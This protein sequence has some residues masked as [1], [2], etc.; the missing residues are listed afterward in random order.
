M[1]TGL[2]SLLMVIALLSPAK[3][4]PP[5]PESQV[6][7]ASFSLQLQ[8]ELKRQ[9]PFLKGTHITRSELDQLVRYLVAHE[10][11]ETVQVKAET[12]EGKTTYYLN[13]GRTRR[14]SK[15]KV[16]GLDHLSENEVRNVLAVDEKSVF[17]QQ[18][19]IEGGERVR[20]LYRDRGF[21]NTVIDL[22]FAR[23]S[24]TEVAVE[25][26]IK[27]GPQTLIEAVTLVAANPEFENAFEKKIRRSLL[28]EPLTDT[29]LNSLRKQMRQLFSEKRFLKAD[30]G[31]PEVKFNS[32]ESKASLTFTITNSEQYLVDLNG[33]LQKGRGSVM[34]SMDL[35]NFFSTNP[36][37]G[38]E[39]ATRVKNFYLKEGFARVEVRGEELATNKAFQKV[40]F[41]DV[42][43]GPPVKIK[44]IRF[45]GRY[46]FPENYYVKF[47]LNHSSEL[48]QD[49]LYNRED[50]EAGLK[51]LIIDRQN[52]GYLRAKVVSVKTA[53][54]GTHKEEVIITVNLEEGPLTI[55]ESLTFEGNSSFSESQLARLVGLKVNEALKLNVLEDGIAK[56]KEFY[57]NSGYLEMNLS[58]ERE[59][60]VNYNA[61]STQASVKFKIYE[62]PKIVVGSV[63]IEGNS[64]T[65]DYVILKELEFKDGDTLTPQ[66]IEE[67]TR[68][69]QRLGHFNTV[70][71]KTLEEK[72]QISNRTVIVRVAD[73]D[74]GLI[75]LG[76]GVN[77]ELGLTVRGYAGLAYRNILGTGRGI[78]GRVEGSYNTTNI[79]YLEHKANV[80]YL[81]PYL[82][83][84]RTNGR[85][86][87][88]LSEYVSDYEVRKGTQSKQITWSL[89][90][91]VTS[92]LFVSYDL[93]SSN[94]LRDF[95]L[96]NDN[97]NS[98]ERTET[99][100]VTTGPNI[101][102][103]YRDHP[104]NPTAG[105]FT[106]LNAEYG[107]P[108]L[109]SSD[110]IHYA[111]AFASFTHYKSVF[112]PGW[113][114]A[115]S[116]RGGVMR[117]F[118]P[119]GGVPYD[120]KGFTLGGQSSIRGF[121]PDESFP[122][123]SDFGV[124]ADDSATQILLKGAASTYLLK[125]EIRF[126]IY[127]SIGGAL[128]YDGGAVFVE[129]VNFRKAGIDTTRQ[130]QFEDPYRDA[131]GVAFRYNTP[132]GAVSLELGYKLDART[133]RNESQWPIFFSIGTF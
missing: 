129:S 83:N 12:A 70:D 84:S 26:K 30:L 16:T 57:Q 127:G 22:E 8:E 102:L 40:I 114:W 132:V 27:E 20:R 79:R 128:F 13:V 110:Y 25:V 37:L 61:D 5:L 112:K 21:R 133:D 101:D 33:V 85:L 55:L 18:S 119:T 28:D 91:N 58:N 17:D 123:R 68:R 96:D 29:A 54:S 38:P 108:T 19:L 67:S 117:N 41:L 69:L 71:I 78:S 48:I 73:R 62:G 59:D 1:R 94:Q 113:V 107:A 105:T 106:R 95:P 51:N 2:L 97:P 103:D 50:I 23:M 65:K 118:S 64:L 47:L 125:S 49:G 87:Y 131:I 93:W 42:Q 98:L 77:S 121:Q 43:E 116:I 92:H 7:L 10:Q 14:V 89:E 104:F 60:L 32:D 124:A 122:N 75:T 109:G 45:S 6:D 111:R 46:T 15:L 11:Y 99:V 86:N 39:L 52:Q 100:I 3:A 63:V 34:D 35:D 72:T 53:Y 44:E 120:K 9:F 115:N 88:T 74:P 76:A 31:A 90:Q 36:N 81:E 24:E 130:V 4:Q 82:F 80:S 66:L 126:P 56:L